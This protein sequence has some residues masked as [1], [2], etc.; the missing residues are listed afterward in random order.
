MP[1]IKCPLCELNYIHA[2]DKLCKI[3]KVNTACKSIAQPENDVADE[4]AFMDEYIFW[5][6]KKLRVDNQKL[7]LFDHLKI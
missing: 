2:D 7:R 4:E 3:C 1:K 6:A 5:K